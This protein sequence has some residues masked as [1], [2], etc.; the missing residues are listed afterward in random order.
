M[1]ASAYRRAGR[2]GS[3]RS[4]G[5]HKPKS[6]PKPYYAVLPHAVGAMQCR[7]SVAPGVVDLYSER[8]EYR[9]LGGTAREWLVEKARIL[10]G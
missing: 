10:R 1:E 3:Y 9:A 8:V 4:I 5:A 7:P 2:R 6:P